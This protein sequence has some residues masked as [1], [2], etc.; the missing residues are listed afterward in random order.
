MEVNCTSKDDGVGM[1]VVSSNTIGDSVDS[2]IKD[3][4]DDDSGATTSDGVSGGIN[5]GEVSGTAAVAVVM[6]ATKEDRKSV[7]RVG[8]AVV[9]T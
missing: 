5:G 7:T 8:V 1:S 2:R 3:I 9:A 4:S 6:M